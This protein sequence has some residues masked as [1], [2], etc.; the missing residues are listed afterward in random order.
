MAKYLL[1]PSPTL[2]FSHNRQNFHIKNTYKIQIFLQ[3]DSVT[4]F[5]KYANT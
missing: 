1:F 2:Y 4:T 5:A 3:S